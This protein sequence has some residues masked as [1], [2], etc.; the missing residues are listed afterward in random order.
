LA[1]RQGGQIG[2]LLLFFKFWAVS[3]ITY[4]IGKQFW[5]IFF[6]EKSVA[7]ILAEYGLGYILGDFFTNSSGHPAERILTKT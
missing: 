7:L 1:E 6:T 2:Q 4:R 5:G 3:Q